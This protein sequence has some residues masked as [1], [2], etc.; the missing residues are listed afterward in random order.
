MRG[1]GRSEAALPQ[2]QPGGLVGQR[3][4]DDH[5]EPAGERVV[6]VGPQVG[7]QHGQAVEGLHSL[8]QVGAL[9]VRVTVVRVAYLAALAEN[10]VRFV[11][12]QDGA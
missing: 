6:E 12:Q 3:E 11:E 10:G 8:Q 1:D 2:R 9:D 4:V 7:C 5:V